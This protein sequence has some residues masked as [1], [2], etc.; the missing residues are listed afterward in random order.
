MEPMV[1]FDP[2]I[3]G[4]GIQRLRVELGYLHHSGIEQIQRICNIASGLSI[5][6]IPDVMPLDLLKTDGACERLHRD[7]KN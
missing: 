7:F 1:Q 6:S 4:S 3:L 2:P 5:S